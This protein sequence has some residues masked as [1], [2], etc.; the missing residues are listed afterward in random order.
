MKE[1]PS[2]PAV[3]CG[4]LVAEIETVRGRRTDLE[5]RDGGGPKLTRGEFAAAASLSERQTKTALR[6]AAVPQAEFEATV[7]SARPPTITAL[8]GLGM[9]YDR[10]RPRWTPPKTETVLVRVELPYRPTGT[11]EE[12]AVTREVATLMAVWCDSSPQARR[13]FLQNIGARQR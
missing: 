8:A 9:R 13:Q 3:R 2:R 4:E 1:G 12:I 7:E 5:L 6:I 10:P 11:L